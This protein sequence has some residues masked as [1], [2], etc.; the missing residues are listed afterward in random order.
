MILN[1]KL[2]VSGLYFSEISLLPV[3]KAN[4]DIGS[5]YLDSKLIKQNS[6]QGKKIR[7]KW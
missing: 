4:K 2:G 6:W 1:T 7:K 5:A 3:Q